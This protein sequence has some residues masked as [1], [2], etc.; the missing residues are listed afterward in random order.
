MPSSEP[1]LLTPDLP[2]R[3]DPKEAVRLVDQLSGRIKTF[4]VGS[5]LLTAAG[6]SLSGRKMMRKTVETLREAALREQI[7][8]PLLQSKNP[9]ETILREMESAE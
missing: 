3:D 5:V 8:A 9:T 4:K 2:D 7:P 1:P 6:P